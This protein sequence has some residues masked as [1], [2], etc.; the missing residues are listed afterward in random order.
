MK[1][2]EQDF[3]KLVSDY[4]DEDLGDGA[5]EEL[6]TALTSDPEKLDVFVIRALMEAELC[7]RGETAA[8]MDARS[9]ERIW[10]H[11]RRSEWLRSVAVA[12]AV[13]VLSALTLYVIQVR[14]RPP[15]A[16]FRVS[17]HAMVTVADQTGE[18]REGTLEQG[19]TLTVTQGS[20][21]VRLEEGV[22]CL[23]QSP[24][25]LH[26]A[27]T[28][29]VRLLQGMARFVVDEQAR[30]F[31][32]ATRMVEVIDLG[33]DFGVDLSVPDQPQVHVMEGEVEVRSLSG[34]KQRTTVRGGSAVALGA[35]GTLQTVPLEAKRFPGKLPEGIPAV[36]FSFDTRQ[37][38]VLPAGGALAEQGGVILPLDHGR[39]PSLVDGRFGQA[40]QFDREGQY[41]QSNWMGIGGTQGRTIS[42]W[43]RTE[44][45]G[46]EEPMAI[47]GWGAWTGSNRMSNLGLRLSGNR[48]TGAMRIVSGRRWLEGVTPLN[49]GRWHHVVVCMGEYSRGNW[50]VTQVF[51]DGRAEDLNPRL[52][53]DE[54]A[55][56]LDTFFTEVHSPDSTPL[57][58]G[59]MA[60]P[61]RLWPIPS[62]RGRI[63]EVIVAA[64]LL[65]ESQAQALYEGRLE[66][67]GLDLGL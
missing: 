21:E 14:E 55:A 60:G 65:T 37:G 44:V 54:R 12:A 16:E 19:A 38:S 28:G 64:G 59:Q 52:P 4:L 23:L 6:A 3:E 46:A 10:G 34:R 9:R 41:A 24:G 11:R 57:I 42:L 49:D 13:L 31:R 7:R 32:V 58:L 39:A 5:V 26:L 1:R 36:R 17:P 25:S 50:P 8:A 30:G 29:R 67:S 22:V 20:A 45:E 15:F 51:V 18:V 40:L 47:L 2:A 62:F 63:D 43:I 53:A 66:D 56:P 35:V 27:D 48:D 61:G 33:T